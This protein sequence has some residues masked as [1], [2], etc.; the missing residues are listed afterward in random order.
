M[1]GRLTLP[2]GLMGTRTAGRL[3][4]TFGPILPLQFF[5]EK[6]DPGRDGSRVRIRLARAV[7]DRGHCRLCCARGTFCGA[8]PRGAARA[9]GM[10]YLNVMTGFAGKVRDEPGAMEVLHQCVRNRHGPEAA[11]NAQQALQTLLMDIAG[12]YGGALAEDLPAEVLD[13]DFGDQARVRYMYG[14]A[15]SIYGGSNEVQK[16]IIAKAILGL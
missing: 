9:V 14:R 2:T 7:R 10:L 12:L 8:T 5:S 1:W 6:L 15:A 13:H 11:V 4:E 16:N 3:T